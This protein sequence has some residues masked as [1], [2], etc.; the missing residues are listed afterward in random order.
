VVVLQKSVIV[1]SFGTSAEYTYVVTP[2]VM[3]AVSGITMVVCSV[4]VLVWTN[5]V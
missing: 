4:L 3:V 2:S 1:L 5:V